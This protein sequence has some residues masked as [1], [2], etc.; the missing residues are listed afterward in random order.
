M[1]FPPGALR[2]ATVSL[3][4][5]VVFFDCRH[6]SHVGAQN[7]HRSL[8]CRRASSLNGR[9]PTSHCSP[10]NGPYMADLLH[11]LPLLVLV[12]VLLLLV[13]FFHVCFVGLVPIAARRRRSSKKAHRMDRRLGNGRPA[14]TTFGASN[15][16]HSA[17][18]VAKRPYDPRLYAGLPS[19][20]I[21]LPPSDDEGGDARSSTLPL[22]SGS[23]QEWAAT[24]SCG[25]GRVET[26]WTYMSLLNEGL[27]DDDDNAAVDLSFQLSS[28]S[29]A[30]ATHTRIINPHPG[31][32]C[33]HNTH[34]G[35][36]GPRDGG[37]PQS[38]C[39]GGGKRNESTSTIDGGV[40]ARERSEWMRLSPLSRSG[41]GAPCARQRPEVLHQEGAD[42]QRDSRQLWAECRQASHQRGTETITRGVQRLHVDEGNEAAAE[43]AR[44]CDDGDGDNDCNS[45]DLPDI[46][47]LGRKA[48][49]GG[50]T[51]RKG[52]AAKS[53]RNKKMD[54]DTGRS[55]GEGG[56]NF[57]SVGDTIALVRA[58]RDQDLY[59]AGMGTSFAR[60]KTREWKWE[61]VRARL[62]SMGVTRD[63]VDC[64]KKWDNLMQQFKKV[65]KFLN[66][67]GGKDYFKL[68]SKER[69]SEGFNFVMDRSV[70]NE[71]EATTKGDHTIHPKN[72]ADTGAAG[73]V[74]MPAGAG[75]AG[76]TMGSEG[77]GDA[78]NEEQGS[79]RDSTFSAGSG[80][81][82]VT[83]SSA[84]SSSVVNTSSSS[85][86]LAAEGG[87]ME[88]G[89]GDGA[90]Q[91][92]RVAAEVAIAAAAAGSSGNVG[93]VAR[94][95]EE[96]PV[97]EREAT[98]VDNKGEREDEDPLLSR[99]RRGGMARDLADRARLW[100]D[101]K[102]FWTRGEGRR[103][104]NIV[105]ETWEYFVAIA[106]GMQTP[107]VP[108]SVVM[109]KSS[110]TVTRI[111]DPAQLQQ[112]IAR[113]MAAGN[114]ALRV[115]HGWVFKSGNHP[116]GFNVAFQYAL[117]SVA[118]DIARV[119]WN[120]E[121]WSN[122]VSAPVCAHTIDP[123][124]D[125]P[126]W[127]AGT[128]IEDRPEDDDMAAHQE[129]TVIC[130]ARAFLAAVQMGG[131][132]DGGFISHERL[133]RITDCFR[134]MLAACMWLMRIAGDNARNHHEA[135]Y[136]AKL[137]AKPTLVASIHR[138]FD[139]RRSIIRATNA[140]T[141]RLGKANATLGEYP[142]YI[143]DRASCGI[144]FG[145]D[146]SITGP[147]DAKRRDWLGSGPLKDDDAKEDA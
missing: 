53:R 97:V 68:A 34:G 128:N 106:G 1:L 72:L 56:Q 129:S 118:T 86:S 62:Q 20:E 98:R 64:G 123:N 67:S 70:Y 30:A 33:A 84:A 31:A 111:A 19:H 2:T 95:R 80:D 47:P 52:P 23:T 138:A 39:E 77:G 9:P 93:V 44:G 13:V 15:C 142:K 119:M 79:T 75:A 29:R 130:I 35:V 57:W 22:G 78:A 8:F 82:A 88:R 91:E 92:A 133:S 85:S 115:L 122:V 121:E 76:D 16:Q 143:P 6:A 120:G 71:M 21:P 54:D 139:H 135:F 14:G 102:A 103:L 61:D 27:C 12:V 117:E 108:R 132:V 137:V 116:R 65:H 114:I 89:A 141:E 28:S 134:L 105:H 26:P 104:Y 66:L 5:I 3:D 24:Q 63:V 109:P 60:M 59:I 41:S 100:V 7:F 50:A 124:M 110:T 125:L 101:D 32:D 99:V 127:F 81:G 94:A 37:L 51:A 73:G 113:A 83:F 48:T 43:E 90:Q 74:Q 17:G 112:A 69:R 46:R 40:G 49:K 87:S 45:D 144:V 140:V 126:L 136:F 38:L 11:R 55:D 42:I 25:G 145:Q 18:S 131:I 10:L 147:E 58:R 96:V 4:K 36:C 107:P 146:A